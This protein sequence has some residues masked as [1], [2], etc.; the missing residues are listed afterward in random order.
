MAKLQKKSFIFLT[1][2]G[3]IKSASSLEIQHLRS[4]FYKHHYARLP[5]F[6]DQ[7]LLRQLTQDI[8]KAGTYRVNDRDG[9]ESTIDENPATAT[10]LFLMNDPYLLRVI[11]KITNLKP[12]GCFMGRCYQMNASRKDK[13]RWHDDLVDDRRVAISVN[14]S[15]R[16][17]Q[18][19]VLKIRSSRT[20]KVLEEVPNFGHG[21]AVIFRI[22]PDLEHCVS[23]VEGSAPKIAFTG[24]FH[25]RAPL[26]SL[27]SGLNQLGEHA[28]HQSAVLMDRVKASK[29]V[30]SRTVNRSRLIFDSRNRAYYG[31]DAVSSRVWDLVQE[32]TTVRS[33]C[34]KLFTEYQAAHEN[35]EPDVL[36][37][38][39]AFKQKKLVEI[40]KNKKI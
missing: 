3:V 13:M 39:G 36:N 2:S 11:E 21:D 28:P 23:P 38:I 25:S 5:G 40:R 12:L 37:L 19:G 27:K 18:G 22:A 26:F 7:E 14:V 8:E 32:E 30:L 20:K 6:L 17:Y 33:V 35:I 10:F 16:V 34:R 24:W 29:R 31:L 15:P 9:S 4:H 1:R